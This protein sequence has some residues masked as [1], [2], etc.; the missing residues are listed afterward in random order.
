MKTRLLLGS[1]A[2]IHLL[3]LMAVAN[4]DVLSTVITVTGNINSHPVS[5]TGLSA[6]N[7]ATGSGQTT[8]VFT[9]IPPGYN[10]ICYGKSWKTKHH[11]RVA[12]CSYGAANL[13]DISPAG[14]DFSTTIIYENGDSIVS[15]GQ[16]RQVDAN[17]DTYNL[18]VQGTYS[19]PGNC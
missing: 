18:N 1:L 6:T 5:G 11:S 4:A 10:P 15:Q 19:G 14:Y 17:N 16:V 3:P 7:L 9:S 2:I 13:A 12:L 8:I